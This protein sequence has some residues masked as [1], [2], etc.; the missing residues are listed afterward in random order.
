MS[1][2]GLRVKIRNKRSRIK[3]G[4]GV[5]EVNVYLGVLDTW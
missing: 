1:R 4:R 3:K 5:K 2:G